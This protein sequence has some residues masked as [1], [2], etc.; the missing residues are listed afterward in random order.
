M[1]MN[2]ICLFLKK[3][4]SEIIVN[5]FEKKKKSTLES[6]ARSIH[7]FLVRNELKVNKQLSVETMT[8]MKY[9]LIFILEK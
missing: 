6:S 3:I 9:F 7:W 1:I 4:A 5:I 2:M 8:K